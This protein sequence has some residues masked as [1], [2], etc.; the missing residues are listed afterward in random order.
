MLAA[1][2][3]DFRP[4]FSVDLPLDSDR[5][6][7]INASGVFSPEKR[8]LSRGLYTA[9]KLFD[10]GTQRVHR[11]TNSLRYAGYAHA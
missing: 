2:F 8:Q 1:N 11:N 9:E 10:L 4:G 5:L 3:S 7:Q 6:A